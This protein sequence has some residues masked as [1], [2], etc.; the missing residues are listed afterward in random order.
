MNKTII[1][2][3]IDD[4]GSMGYMRGAG[5][6]ENKYLI[7]GKTRMSL[8][9]KMI[10]EEILPTINYCS[11]LFIRTFRTGIEKVGD[12]IVQ[13][14][15]YTPIIYEGLYDLNIIK[16]AIN[17]LI[18]P[19]MGGTPI[20]SAIE[21]ASLDLD[22][23]PNS[24][25]KIILLTDGEE[26]GVGNYVDVAKK[27]SDLKGIPCKIFIVGI[28]QDNAAEIKSKQIANGGYVNLKTTQFSKDELKLALAPLKGDVLQNSIN[29]VQEL[30]RQQPN[31]ESKVFTNSATK[32]LEVDLKSLGIPI[33]K[34]LNEKIEVIKKETRST[35]TTLKI[36]S[37]ERK[38]SDQ[39]DNFKT[40]LS[41][42]I[43]LKEQIRIN[44]LLELGVD[45]TTLTIDNEYSETIR[46]K[47]EYFLHVNLQK[48]Y[49][50]PN[51]KWL[52][53]IEES[54]EH[55]DFEIVDD[56]GNILH[57]IECKG[58]SRIKPTFYLTSDEWHHFLK[59]K[60]IYQ[61]YRIF[62]VETEM[63]A[64]VIENVFESINNGEVVPYLLK[65]EILKENRVFLTF[66]KEISDLLLNDSKLKF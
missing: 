64:V 7:D 55:H 12:K 51:V 29:N 28:G 4:S 58:T 46:K 56:N 47:S 18:D 30:A 52:N 5:Q 19:E 65:P 45:S 20:S 2:I 49:G 44:A 40:L 10:L 57:L 24:D 41:E 25:R 61:I 13:K 16:K 63:E 23:Y 33:V 26:N 35:E 53:E 31:D 36:E 3:L 1:E 39:I 43:S 11:Y 34:E 17:S 60:D 48:K 15:V 59:N 66:K 27:I 21:V 6:D 62:N 54:Y 38:L 42:L 8:I 9:K 50:I 32:R 22:K 14:G 37:L